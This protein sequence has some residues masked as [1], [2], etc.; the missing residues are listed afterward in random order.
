MKKALVVTSIGAGVVA[1]A[2]AARKG[3]SMCSSEESRTAMWDRM[4]QRM[5]EMPEDFPPR[6]MFDNVQTA[7]ENTERILAILEDSTREIE[8]ELA[9]APV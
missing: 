8:T 9:S 6:I 2:V 1:I 5:E 4:R 3:A 7:R